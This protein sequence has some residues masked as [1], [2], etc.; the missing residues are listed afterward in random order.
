MSVRGVSPFTTGKRWVLRLA[1]KRLNES[2]ALSC[3]GR[4]FHVRGA[5]NLKDFASNL[6][7][8]MGMLRKFDD[9]DFRLLTCEC[10]EKVLAT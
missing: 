4:P 9:S 5:E 6:F 3:G 2:E 8:G 10:E 7:L 1:L